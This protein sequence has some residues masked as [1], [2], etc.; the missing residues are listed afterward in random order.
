MCCVYEGRRFLSSVKFS[1]NS[2]W[3]SWNL[4]GKYQL[5]TGSLE[6]PRKIPRS[7]IFVFLPSFFL[8][9][10]YPLF[11][12]SRNGRKYQFKS[13]GFLEFQGIFGIQIDISRKYYINLNIKYQYLLYQYLDPSS[14][15]Q[16]E[17]K[18]LIFDL[19]FF[20]F[21]FFSYVSLPSFRKDLRTCVN[22]NL[23]VNIT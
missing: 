9:R 12:R 17:E 14:T 19:S 23:L 6:L 10:A 22:I 4:L 13:T 3:N 16:K 5:S 8:T 11:E 21:F 15:A 18:F 20:L 1:E 2:S 7:S